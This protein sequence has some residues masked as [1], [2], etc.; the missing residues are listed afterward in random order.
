MLGVC[1]DGGCGLSL[2]SVPV[3]NYDREREVEKSE[4]AG[5]E[6]GHVSQPCFNAVLVRLFAM[7]LA[8]GFVR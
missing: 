6:G 2:R 5:S 8:F 4:G 1:R 7:V 3:A